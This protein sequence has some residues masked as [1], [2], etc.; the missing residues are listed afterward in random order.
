M[1]FRSAVFNLANN[2]ETVGSLATAT[3]SDTAA[4]VTLGSGTLSA[5]DDQAS[6]SDASTTFAGVISGTGGFTKQGTG[7][8]TLSG[9]N[10]YSG[11]TAIDV[12]GGTISVTGTLGADSSPASYAGQVSIGTS[13]TFSYGSTS[14]QT[15]TGKITGAGAIT[16][17][18]NSTL[19]LSPSSPSDYTG[20]TTLSAGTIKI[21]VASALG[22][23][24]KSTRLNSSHVSESRMPSSA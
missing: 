17:S 19:T 8:L 4:S 20:A 16:K 15:L 23:D 7:T 22:A 21:T 9:A 14:N 24:R 12:S 2:S 10:T 3:T 5:G 13:G 18:G 6:G 11:N 1:L